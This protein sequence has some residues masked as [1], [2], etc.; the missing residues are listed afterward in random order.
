MK[1]PPFSIQ[2][3]EEI[4]KHKSPGKRSNRCISTP[5]IPQIITRYSQAD[6]VEYVYVP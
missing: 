1:V 3:E 6:L 4:V 5:N 2:D